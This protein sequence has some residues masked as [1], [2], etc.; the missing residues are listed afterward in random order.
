MAKQTIASQAERR[1]ILNLRL[2]EGLLIGLIAFCI[3]IFMALVTYSSGDPGWSRTGNGEAVS[4]AV[5]PAGAWMA[6]IFFALFG[7][8]AYLFQ[9]MLAFRAWRLF[10]DRLS[11]Q[12]F[13]SL[14]LFCA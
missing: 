11:G 4:N 5:G 8:M 10:K 7:Y 6:D 12:A 14:I 1:T 9:A 3:F 2:R 13:D